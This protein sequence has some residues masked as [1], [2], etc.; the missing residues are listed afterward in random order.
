M[1]PQ[2][3]TSTPKSENGQFVHDLNS[4]F[5]TQLG[6]SPQSA[7]SVLCVFTLPSCSLMASAID[8]A[9]IVQA[10]KH[11][12]A[13]GWAT[14]QVDAVASAVPRTHRGD[15]RGDGLSLS[16][17]AR[18]ALK[19][20]AQVSRQPAPTTS[21]MMRDVDLRKNLYAQSCSQVARPFLQGIIE[22]MT[23]EVMTLA[24]STLRSRREFGRDVK[25]KLCNIALVYDTELKLTT[26]K[27]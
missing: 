27:F 5:H 13:S 2:M 14:R 4:I 16:V 7:R 22:Y 19:A 25:E 8:E 9:T 10:T 11:G 18:E 12:F 20:V 15:Q 23:N 6:T 1:T 21:I 3:L 17:N 24:R 26:E